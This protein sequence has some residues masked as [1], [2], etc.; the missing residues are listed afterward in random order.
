MQPKHAL[1]GLAIVFAIFLEIW[2]PEASKGLVRV[3]VRILGL[4]I[5][6]A[7]LYQAYQALRSAFLGINTDGSAPVPDPESASSRFGAF[8][9]GVIA[10]ALSVIGLSFAFGFDIFPFIFKIFA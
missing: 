9:W 7:F 5:S 10:L 1:I 3:A 6:C 4:L 8:S 2:E